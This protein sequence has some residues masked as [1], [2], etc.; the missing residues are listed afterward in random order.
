MKTEDR[1]EGL[2][3]F[4]NIRKHAILSLLIF[5]LF[6]IG[7]SKD[8]DGTNETPKAV[9][10]TA[11]LKA[12]G[13]SAND[14]LSNDNFDKLLIEVA[15][16]EDFRPKSDAITDFEAFLKK[17]TFK[18]NIEV[19]YNEL[20][21]PEKDSLSLNEIADLEKENRTAYND[22]KTLAIYIYFADAPSETD[23]EDED[24][25][26]LGA[27]YRNTSM[28]IH[29]STVKKLAKQSFLISEAD[30]EAATLN[31]EFGH[32]FGLV[33][34]GTTPVNEHEDPEAE[35][36]CNEENCLMR[37]ELQFGTGMKKMLASRVS[38]GLS[39][40]PGLDPECILDLQSNGGR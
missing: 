26:T 34:L 38:K 22:G 11:N 28:V 12:A 37:A 39:S 27:V 29:E 21:S 14:I 19:M 40:A 17:H 32:L 10:K 36:H 20:P 1:Y 7:C 8:S 16:V 18:D 6:F 25:V 4:F 9:D 35:N 33:D 23:D 2:R 24:L 30:I 31:H 13:E 5:T 15:Y 3:Y